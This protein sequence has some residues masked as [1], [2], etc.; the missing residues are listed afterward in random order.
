MSLAADLQPHIR[1]RADFVKDPS[2]PT[3]LPRQAPQGGFYNGPESGLNEKSLG[4]LA[5]ANLNLTSTTSMLR[6]VGAAGGGFAAG[7]PA[8]GSCG[9]G[10]CGPRQ[11]AQRAVWDRRRTGKPAARAGPGPSH[12]ELRTMD[13][14][15]IYD[16]RSDCRCDCDCDC[17]CQCA[18]C[19]CDCSHAP[20]FRTRVGRLGHTFTPNVADVA[21]GQQECSRGCRGWYVRDGLRKQAAMLAQSI[22]AKPSSSSSLSAT[23]LAGRGPSVGAVSVCVDAYSNL[24]AAQKDSD[25]VPALIGNA[26]LVA[27]REAA[28]LAWKERRISDLAEARYQVS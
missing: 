5:R 9:G 20:R 3:N 23:A 8:T 1:A 12:T 2:K 4:V 27:E 22:H 28:L 10:S 13:R 14:L 18:P 25:S 26:V 11:Y 17:D 7:S 24:N 15:G 16:A 6:N 21:Q 19:D